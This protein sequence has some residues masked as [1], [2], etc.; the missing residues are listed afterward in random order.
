MSKDWPRKGAKLTKEERQDVPA[1]MLFGDGTWEHATLSLPTRR[2]P[3]SVKSVAKLK[4]PPGDR[5]YAVGRY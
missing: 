1:V 3:V 4:P 2:A 5:S